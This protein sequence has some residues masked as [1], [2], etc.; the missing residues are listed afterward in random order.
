MALEVRMGR[1]EAPTLLHHL[2]LVLGVYWSGPT[3]GAVSQLHNPFPGIPLVSTADIYGRY[4]S[5]TV[6]SCPGQV[7]GPPFSLGS[8]SVL[9][10]PAVPQKFGS[11]PSIVL[12][13]MSH[14]A[15]LATQPPTPP[16]WLPLL[17]SFPARLPKER[18]LLLYSG[19]KVRPSLCLTKWPLQLAV[20]TP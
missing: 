9:T 1:R 7:Q 15:A 19:A 18:F 6:L 11:D 2:V 10:S 20:S 14:P 13:P 5:Q 4:N 8:T 3:R 16:Q 17:A 12:T